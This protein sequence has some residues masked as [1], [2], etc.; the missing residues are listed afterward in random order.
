[1]KRLTLRTIIASDCVEA[2]YFIDHQGDNC[3]W[4]NR[5]SGNDHIHA[6]ICIAGEASASRVKQPAHGCRLS[7]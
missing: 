3:T 4:F 1:M 2:A 5:T 7:G 6:A